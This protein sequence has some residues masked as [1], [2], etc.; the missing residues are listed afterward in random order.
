MCSSLSLSEEG[1]P[2]W[3]PL[4]EIDRLDLVDDLP[5]L[6]SRVLAMGPNDP[7]FYALY[8]YDGNDELVVTF[9]SNEL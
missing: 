9:P 3:V 5:V 6:L 8:T 2:E 1:K 4:D 7:P